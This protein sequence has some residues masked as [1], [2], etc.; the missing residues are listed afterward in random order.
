VAI[1]MQNILHACVTATE[2]NHTKLLPRLS[3]SFLEQLCTGLA[4]KL[5]LVIVREGMDYV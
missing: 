1:E 5:V 3:Q 4:D 2:R